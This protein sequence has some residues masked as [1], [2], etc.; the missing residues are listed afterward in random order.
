MLRQ[1]MRFA[2][3]V[4]AACGPIYPQSPPQSA[5]DPSANEP[6]QPGYAGQNQYGQPPPPPSTGAPGAYE[7]SAAPPSRTNQPGE[8]RDPFN[9]GRPADPYDAPARRPPP[10]PPPAAKAPPGLAAAFIAAHNARRGKHCAQPLTW[11]PQLASVAQG[12]ANTLVR[13]GCKF[14]HSGGQFGE[15]LAAGSTGS[16]DPEGV[17]AMWYDEI[18]S[19]DFRGGGFSMQTGH[20]TQV[21]WRGTSQ[22]GCGVASC[23]GLDI[24]VCNYDPAGNV[25]GEYR[26][27]VMSARDCR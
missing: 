3:L 9:N 12:W 14:E 10:P 18:K 7:D 16:L 6:G 11:S 19:F 1:M 27:N 26:Q 15:N 8:V 17:V 5:G 21:V 22:V 20:F 23:N 4:L 13:K 25:E 2:S 24:Y